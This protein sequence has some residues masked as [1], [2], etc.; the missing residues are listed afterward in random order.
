MQAVQ[1]N[2][3]EANDLDAVLSWRE[4]L[5][6]TW[7]LRRSWWL[8]VPVGLVNIGPITATIFTVPH[9][10]STAWRRSAMTAGS[11]AAYR[12]WGAPLL[13]ENVRRASPSWKKAIHEAIGA[14]PVWVGGK[15][16]L[17]HR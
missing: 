17:F 1:F 6:L 12:R 2:D 15:R 9:W 5:I 13:D 10:R 7:A 11:I 16:P 4:W 3:M 14:G 8:F